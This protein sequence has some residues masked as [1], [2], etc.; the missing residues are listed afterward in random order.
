MENISVKFCKER[1]G[2]KEIMETSLWK[3]LKHWYIPFF[4]SN[5]WNT[6]CMEIVPSLYPLLSYEM[7][8][9]GLRS[10]ECS[11]CW[12]CRQVFPSAFW[13]SGL[14][15]SFQPWSVVV[16]VGIYTLDLYTSLSKDSVVNNNYKETVLHVL[17][18]QHIPRVWGWKPLFCRVHHTGFSW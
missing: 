3:N 16:T 10:S 13:F 5:N 11:L 7:K 14:V 18:S 8:Y 2:S 15:L 1:K 12:I 17:D 9:T 4:S 6:I